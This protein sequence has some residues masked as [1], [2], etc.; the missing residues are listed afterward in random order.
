MKVRI[1]HRDERLYKAVE[2]G[3]KRGDYRSLDVRQ[4]PLQTVRE[5]QRALVATKME[6]MFAKPFA[7]A[8]SGHLDSVKSLGICHKHVAD[9][10]SG[11]CDGELR[12]W[13]L[14]NKK[15]LRSVHK[16]HEGFINVS[17]CGHWLA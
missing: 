7:H 16:A 5:Y 12:F 15:C 17:L 11:S 2:A 14:T 13:N 9:F 4:H 8:F 1:L 3:T 10:F 6:R